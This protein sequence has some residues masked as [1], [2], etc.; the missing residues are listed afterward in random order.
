MPTPTSNPHR[1]SVWHPGVT[2]AMVSAR[3]LGTLG[4]RTHAYSL[5]P[6]AGPEL[7]QSLEIHTETASVS[8]F[9]RA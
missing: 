3:A 8:S 1:S 2:W 5:G 7:A 9:A 4:K 6:K